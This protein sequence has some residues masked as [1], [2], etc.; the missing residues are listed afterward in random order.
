MW[1]FSASHDHGRYQAWDATQ[2]FP[3][4][5]TPLIHEYH[6]LLRNHS[7]KTIPKWERK[8]E[9]LAMHIVFKLCP[10]KIDHSITSVHYKCAPQKVGFRFYA[11]LM[12]E[13]SLGP[14]SVLIT[15]TLHLR[16]TLWLA[17]LQKILFI[18][19]IFSAYFY[20]LLISTIVRQYTPSA[21][22]ATLIPVFKT[23]E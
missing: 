11:K 6:S 17:C 23:I 13:N 21:T 12:F 2:N 4:Q 19:W 14:V 15:P 1:F 5:V 3:A 16:S 8:L 7:L 10:T 18:F 9:F 20:F 22:E